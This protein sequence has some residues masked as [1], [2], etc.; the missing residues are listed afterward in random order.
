[1]ESIAR[2]LPPEVAAGLD[3]RLK[4]ERRQRT[5]LRSARLHAAQA[6]A[7]PA[8]AIVI[9]CSFARDFCRPGREMRSLVKQVRW[10]CACL[11][12]IIRTVQDKCGAR[13]ALKRDESR[14]CCNAVQVILAVRGCMRA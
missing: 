4:R 14:G 9:D 13:D 1:M 8:P 5:E 12:P 7:V 10:L 3:A 11:R 2:A 6:G